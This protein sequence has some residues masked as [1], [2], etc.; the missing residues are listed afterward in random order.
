[1]LHIYLGQTSF[2][3]VKVQLSDDAGRSLPL[4]YAMA[5]LQFYHKQD[6]S[7]FAEKLC[8]TWSELN[9]TVCPAIMNFNFSLVFLLALHMRSMPNPH[10][11][12]TLLITL[13]PT[14]G[15]VATSNTIFMLF[16]NR[17]AYYFP[18]LV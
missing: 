10:V 11:V 9:A 17:F 6:S 4:L 12:L 5:H 2:T 14:C 8:S 1:M 13:H 15:A 7:Q 18:S 3:C 16:H